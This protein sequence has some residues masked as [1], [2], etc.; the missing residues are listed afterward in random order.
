MSIARATSPRSR[1]AVNRRQS[2]LR[3]SRVDHALRAADDLLLHLYRRLTV[4]TRISRRSKP[5][6][7]MRIRLRGC[8]RSPLLALI[9]AVL[10][11]VVVCGGLLIAAESIETLVGVKG[12]SGRLVPALDHYAFAVACFLIPT[13]LLCY[14]RDWWRGLSI[15]L[16]DSAIE[17]W[18]EIEVDGVRRRG[19]HCWPAGDVVTID[20]PPD[21]PITLEIEGVGRCRIGVDWKWRGGNGRAVCELRRWRGYLRPRPLTRRVATPVIEP[22]ATLG[23]FTRA[24]LSD[25]HVIHTRSSVQVIVGTVLKQDGDV[26]YFHRRWPGFFCLG[27]TFGMTGR[28]SETIEFGYPAEELTLTADELWMI[29]R[30]NVDRIQRFRRSEILEFRKNRFSMMLYIR[31]RGREPQDV[32]GSQDFGALFADRRLVPLALEHIAPLIVADQHESANDRR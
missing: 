32:I 11:T 13:F 10:W 3:L 26:E 1:R 22:S 16:D 24:A 12:R 23:Y 5:I 8:L 15:S 29:S 2:S 6:P 20:C 27:S 19:V 9:H 30:T 21:G 7:A 18:G 25:T 17:F 28:L 14:T 4:V 31:V